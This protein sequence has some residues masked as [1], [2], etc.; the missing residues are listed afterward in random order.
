VK[1]PYQRTR[2]RGGGLAIHSVEETTEIEAVETEKQLVR[3]TSVLIVTWQ[4]LRDNL[5]RMC[6]KAENISTC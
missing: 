6:R 1:F 4:Q 2:K 3:V 5:E